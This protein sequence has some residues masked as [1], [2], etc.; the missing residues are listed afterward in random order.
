MTPLVKQ[1]DGRILMID[2]QAHEVLGP[3]HG[4]PAVSLRAPDGIQHEISVQDFQFQVSIG[5]V[6]DPETDGLRN[7][8]PNAEEQFE[9]AFRK[10]VIEQTVALE[11]EGITWPQRLL[12]MR[13]R[14]ER[15]AKFS[16]RQKKFPSERTIQVWMKQNLRHGVHG[17]RDRTFESGNVQAVM[18]LSSK[19]SY[20]IFWKSII[21]VLTASPKRSWVNWRLRSIVKNAEPKASN[22]IRMGPKSYAG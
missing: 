4:R 5:N 13:E 19:R 15:D 16:K 6:L 8:L 11:A 20:T 10:A 1:Y 14:F 2:E 18:M 17:L 12:I 7:R 3:I 22:Q 21:S 9:V